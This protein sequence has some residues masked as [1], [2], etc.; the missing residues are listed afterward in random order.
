[1]PQ[2][3]RHSSEV[4]EIMGLIPSW[5]VRWGI[6]VIAG[7]FALIII[8]CCII[9]YPETVTA[10]VVITTGN[11]PSELVLRTGGIIDTLCVENNAHVEQ[12]DMLTAVVSTASTTDIIA[13]KRWLKEVEGISPESFVQSDFITRYYT[14]GDVS[15]SWNSFT[16]RCIDYRHYLTANNIGRKK[17]LIE[18]QI[19]KNGEYYQR[20][21]EQKRLSDEDM[22][23]SEK[24]F[25]RDSL[26]HEKKIMSDYE[27]EASRQK[28]LSTRSS[29]MNFAASL[30]STELNILQFKQQLI[31][32]TMQEEEERKEHRLAIIQARQQTI[33]DIEAWMERYAV[34]APISGR[35]QLL[36]VWSEYQHV[37]QG[38]VI[39]TIVPDD[40]NTVIGRMQIASVGFGKVKVEQT[41]N[42]KLNGF[43]YME[44]G[45]L[46]GRIKTL[47]AVPEQIQFAS[48]TSVV[49]KAE[50]E[51]PDGLKSTYNKDLPLI[52]EM[53]GTA[54]IITDDM[55]LIEQFIRPIKSLFKN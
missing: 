53:D 41:V 34:T 23:L 4:Q 43:P 11:P 15:S 40:I 9:K 27:Y 42:I 31:E 36:N 16:T 12:N 51:F 6:A 48:G 3:E 45:V 10:S 30:S 47:S 7:I 20:L 50:V 46:R 52:R 28:L 54:E 1:M 5:I 21:V 32:L 2:D 38:T 14:L 39:A 35:V 22:Q 26:L 33:A 55:R 13:V 19:A 18:E 8:G 44:Y 25:V 37:P 49:Y 17:L 29:N 24:S